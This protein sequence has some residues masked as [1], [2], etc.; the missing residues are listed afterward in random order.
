VPFA[1]LDSG[2][3]RLCGLYREARALG[4]QLMM[5]L[6]EP[7]TDGGLDGLDKTMEAREALIQEASILPFAG[8]D[9][10]E[11]LYE[12]QLLTAQQQKLEETLRTSMIALRQGEAH[13]QGTRTAVE[14]FRRLI[15]SEPKSRW[16]N[17]KR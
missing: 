7:L 6:S 17:E 12:L 13:A 15:Q 11:S 9:L 2:L 16:L 1:H 3:T 4:D 5:V 14:S 10:R 8:G